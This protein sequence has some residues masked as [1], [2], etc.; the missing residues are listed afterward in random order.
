MK[1]GKRT[2]VVKELTR[3]EKNKKNNIKRIS[4]SAAAAFVLF[5]CLIVIQSSILNQEKTFEV[6]QVIKDIPVSTKLTEKNIDTYLGLKE[7]QESL[8]P[9]KYI[10][11]KKK[12]LDKFVNRD[13]KANDIITEDGVTDTEKLYKD[14]I[15]NPIEISLDASGLSVAVSGIIREGDYINI[16]GL[17]KPDEVDGQPNDVFVVDETYTFK[18]VYITKAFGGDG[19]R[20]DSVNGEEGSEG[21]T[22]TLFNI[23]IS[24]NDADLFNEMIKNC[25]IKLSKLLYETTED[26]TKFL[27]RTNKKA[28]VATKT[29]GQGVSEDLDEDQ[30]ETLDDS[31]TSDNEIKQSE[32]MEKRNKTAR[33]NKADN[34]ATSNN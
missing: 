30:S 23:I 25:E 14:S 5:V 8:I 9:S 28:A 16:Y 7:V 33:N 24:E 29:T 15:E 21:K 27:T 10:T 2:S 13:Y 18:H 19:S 6:Y 12:I 17:R 3:Q 1:L 32:E 11:D 26:Y 31:E 34:K 22:A 4:I 20:V